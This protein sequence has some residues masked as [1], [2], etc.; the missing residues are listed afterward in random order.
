MPSGRI[1]TALSPGTPP[2]T[3]IGRGEHRAW[4]QPAAAVR[5]FL[6]SN[7]WRSESGKVKGVVVFLC[8]TAALSKKQQAILRRLE[9]TPM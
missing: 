2:R 7:Q 4:A 5:E 1:P 3:D 9:Q 6:G 8:S